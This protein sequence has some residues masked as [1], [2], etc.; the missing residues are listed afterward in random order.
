MR[1]P[2][3]L[4]TV[5][6]RKLGED[7]A[8]RMGYLADK[9]SLGRRSFDRHTGWMILLIA[10]AEEEFQQCLPIIKVAVADPGWWTTKISGTVVPTPATPRRVC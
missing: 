5:K 6:A 10:R 7:P 3:G 4:P 9:L 8:A 1:K 2:A